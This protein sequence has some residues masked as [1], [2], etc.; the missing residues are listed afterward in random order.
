MSTRA[1]AGLAIA[2]ALIVAG[3]ESS[4]DKSAR[5]RK[6]GLKA[7]SSQQ[8]LVIHGHNAD[9]R[10]V[11]TGV[12]T[13]SNGTAAAVVLRNI[14]PA[15]LALVPI[16]INVLGARGKSVFRNNAPGL[17]SALTSVS[18]LPPGQEMT[19]VNDQVTPS[20]PAVAVRAQIGASTA[21]SL[22]QLPKIV[23]TQPHLVNDPTS[24]IEAVGK[25]TN[26]SQVAQLKLVV[27][28]SAWRGNR[29]VAAGRAAITRLGPGANAQYHAYLIGN[30]QGATFFT[31][32]AP[33]T[34][35]R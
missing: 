17:E 31:V 18:A 25:V 30:P 23:A 13:D 12:V 6:E 33:P 32:E 24:G 26:Q 27:Y 1:A 15:P 9:V 35:L 5:L 8:G 3:C 16:A 7:I 22:A 10:V 2:L 14:R 11:R 29:L 21:G 4:Q 20:G 28:V 19:W 34:V